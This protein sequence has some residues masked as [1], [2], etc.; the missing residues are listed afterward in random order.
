MKNS[1]L[2]KVLIVLLCSVSF[3][4]THA[5]GLS[6]SFN[7]TENDKLENMIAD[8]K[9]YEI[10]S[11]TLSG[12]VNGANIKYI[13]D[14]NK[15][16]KL[17]FLNLKECLYLETYYISNEISRTYQ[18]PKGYY[19]EDVVNEYLSS[20]EYGSYFWVYSWDYKI[21]IKCYDI[22][23][24]NKVTR[25]F[26]IIKGDGRD[27][28]QHVYKEVLL[29]YSESHPRLAF[30]DCYFSELT[31]PN[32][33]ECIGGLDCRFRVKSCDK[34]VFG[35]QINTIGENAFKD[36]HIG[37]ITINSTIN[38]IRANAFENTTGNILS[39]PLFLETAKYIGDNAFKNS[40]LLQGTSRSLALQATKIGNNAFF[41]A[42]IPLNI[43][44]PNI[45]EIG[46]SSFMSSTVVN[47]DMGN[48]IKKL[49]N[50]TFENC[51]ALKTFGGGTNI[52]QIGDRAFYGCKQLNAFTPSNILRTIG[53]EAF[54]NNMDLV[55]FSIPNTTES[56]GYD[57]F[58]NSGL[59]ELDLGVFCNYHRDIVSG[60]DNLEII[61]VNSSNTKM[62]SANG[63]LLSKDESRIITYPCAKK[64]VLYEIS[65]KVT[66]IED[67]AFYS[68]NKLR[69]LTISENVS[70]I[71]KNAFANSSIN[72]IRLL[73]SIPPKVTNNQSGLNQ[74][75][76]N[77]YVHE[78]DYSTYY[79]ANYWGDFNNLFILENDVSPWTSGIP[80][81]SNTD[82]TGIVRRYDLNGR[83]VM[84]TYR[85]ISIIKKSNGTSKK[86][87][88][89]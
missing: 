23:D 89:K 16:G 73:P 24:N 67:S 68:V 82:N 28:D 17:R 2:S 42:V 43:V 45:E 38:E 21:T 19:I 29:N 27:S 58:A 86:V 75:N 83:V 59:K 71:G 88:A 77:L 11:L 7:L 52:E 30:Q 84:S 64:D 32:N 80:K 62:K 1:L 6:L 76:V 70:K 54:A 74:S 66:E 8:S 36:S 81:I 60:C 44:L 69:A 40:S 26:H 10:I 4:T 53:Q 37:I 34:I 55:S 63:V 9:K 14:I 87:F 20:L 56:I 12:Y 49:S 61:S 25:Y 50:S 47:V 18:G 33:I 13:T 3:I 35:E 51:G 5:Q 46:N 65:S 57:A 31:I 22:Y 72:N 15:N 48:K 41:N 85:G 79:I 78:R 39:S